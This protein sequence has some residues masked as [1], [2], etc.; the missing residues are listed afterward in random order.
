M[1]RLIAGL[2]CCALLSGCAV[3]GRQQRDQRISSDA[4]DQVEKGM[5]KA[6]VVELLGAPH[7]IEY[8]R[9][10]NDPV[11]E[12]AYIYEH[13]TTKYTGIALAFINFGNSDEKR[14]RVV[15]FFDATGK[16]SAVG[17]S[18]HAE[19]ANFGFPFGQ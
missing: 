5:T 10:D 18:L 16:V 11:H 3:M 14:D 19:E 7:Q 6:K 9:K 8:L 2:V 1:T 15:I 12:H 17:K 4:A 13:I